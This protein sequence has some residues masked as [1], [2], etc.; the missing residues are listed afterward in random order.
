MTL[1]GLAL[2]ALLLIPAAAERSHLVLNDGRILRGPRL[3][4]V[5]GGVRVHFEAMAVTV[6]K[7]LIRFAS[8]TDYEETDEK[9]LVRLRRTRTWRGRAR[10]TT[11][12]FTI[13]STTPSWVC[14]A[15]GKVAEETLKS[16]REALWPDEHPWSLDYRIKLYCTAAQ[17]RLI[18]GA[19]HGSVGSIRIIPPY[20]IDLYHDAAEPHRSMD[21]LRYLTALSVIH[22]R[23]ERFEVPEFPAG[24]LAEHLSRAASHRQ[25]K[26]A[27]IAIDLELKHIPSVQEAI[28]QTGA[29]AESAWAWGLLAY[30]RDD[31]RLLTFVNALRAKDEM[32]VAGSRKGLVTIRPQQVALVFRRHFGI[33]ADAKC[34]AFEREWIAWLG[35]RAK[36]SHDPEVAYRVALRRGDRKRAAASLKEAIATGNANRVIALAYGRDMLSLGNRG[37]AVT[38]LRRAFV[39][40]PIDVVL[41]REMARACAGL[42][43]SDEALRNSR[44]AT[45]LEAALGH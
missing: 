18:G 37:E 6:P 24:A 19:S 41:V 10:T 31:P 32:H 2:T 45:E 1:S 5:E 12:D 35:K 3:E 22:R 9:T 40:D 4:A 42:K 26:L 39:M 20:E 34:A 11:K 14:K 16:M 25:E 29:H 17:F 23:H 44:L 30:F 28:L 8:A 43:L 38:W 21:T 33:E 13:E 27:H 7:E 36:K 15:Y